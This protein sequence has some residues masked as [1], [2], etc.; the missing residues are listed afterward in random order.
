MEN[1]NDGK[2]LTAMQRRFVDFYE[3]NATDAAR[4]AGYSD[5]AYGRQLITNPNVHDAIQE[6]VVEERS[7]LIA[8]RKERQE[9]WTAIARGE[10]L[11]ETVTND[12]EVVTLPVSIKDRLTAS[13]L[14]G[15][16]EGDFVMRKDAEK[17]ITIVNYRMIAPDS[18]R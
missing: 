2:K 4:Q 17:P 5:P 10:I 12:G 11:I 13:A 7:G 14:L 16:S 3:G 9:L 15:K 1:R 8:S 6:R 18:D